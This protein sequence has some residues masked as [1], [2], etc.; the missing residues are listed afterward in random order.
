M[1]FGVRGA[2]EAA[3]EQ[4]VLQLEVGLLPAIEMLEALAFELVGLDEPTEALAA[5]ADEGVAT[6]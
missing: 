3:L 5:L 6:Q 4:I 2:V 1:A